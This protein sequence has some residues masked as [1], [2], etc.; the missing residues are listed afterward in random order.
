MPALVT[1]AERVYFASTYNG[2]QLTGISWIDKA[3]RTRGATIYSQYDGSYDL[4]RPLLALASCGL[5]WTEADGILLSQLEHPASV[6]VVQGMTRGL[7][8]DETSIYWSSAAGFIGKIPK[9]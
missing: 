8:A 7:I 9:P 3:T 1:D 4:D 2:T 5:L 6:L